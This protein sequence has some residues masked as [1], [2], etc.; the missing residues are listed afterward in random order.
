VEPSNLGAVS[1]LASQSRRLR[2]GR[3]LKLRGSARFLVSHR[4]LLWRITRNEITARFA[5][6]LL[7]AGWVF[8]GPLLLLG[9]YGLVYVAIYKIKAPGMT[10]TV[11][12]LYVFSGLVPFLVT[13]ESL[14]LGVASVVTNKSVLSNTVFPI[15]LAPVKAVLSSLATMTVGLAVILVG[16]LATGNFH[17]TF[18]LFPCVL[19]LHV[20]WLIGLNW[21]LSLLN[22]VFRDI[23]NMLAAVL[24]MLLVLSP[25]AYVP[26]QVPASLKPFLALNPFAYFI[27]G[28][29]RLL[30]LGSVPSAK[31]WAGLVVMSVATFAFGSWFFSKAK[32]V[33]IDYV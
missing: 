4:N 11:Y 25:I 31:H 3:A 12:V 28:Y 26:A 15:D 29:Q 6:S 16:V 19:V 8:L 24:M 10:S 5:G 18:F 1:T 13:G 30:V 17:W 33:I 9:V 14:A 32:P 7:G 20:M 2:F 22:V 23:Q 27:V 21:F